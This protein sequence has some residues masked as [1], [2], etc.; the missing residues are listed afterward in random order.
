MTAI[1]QHGDTG[2]IVPRAGAP[3][4]GVPFFEKICY[5]FGDAGGTVITGLIANFLTFY[6]TDV[7]GLAPGIVGILFLS[8]R[9]F[10]AVSDPLIGIM[11]DRTRTRWG[12]FRPYLLWTAIPVGLS[13]FLTFQSPDLGYDGK[14]AYAAATYFLLALSYSL[15]NVPYCALITRMTDSAREGVSCQSVRFAMVAIA[16]FTV[17]V[18]LPIMVRHLGGADVARG[19]CDGVAILSVAAVAMFVIC[20]LFV[21][22]RVPETGAAEPPLRIAIANTLKNDQ[23]RLTFVMTLLLI[24]IFNTK[25][26]AA[27]YFITYVL[28]GDSTYQALFF[29]TAT[30][31][32]FLGSVLV[33]LFTRRFDVRTVYVWVNLLL[34]AGHFAAFFV[35]GGYPMLWLMLVALCCIALGCTLPLHFTLIQLADQYGEWKLGTRSSGMSFAFNQFFVKLAWALAG[36]L[37]S[38][39]LVIVSYKAGAGNQTPLSLTGIRLLSTVIPG[40][41]HLALALTASRLILNRATIDRMTAARAA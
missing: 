19:Y 38:G 3:A 5:G 1:A 17:S 27:L 35:P 2:G 29:G 26:G 15:N 7:F 8:L 12:K 40:V 31:G 11:A 30:A 20:F 14:V 10:D 41:M 23:L 34:V 36:A 21:R 25:G 18:G 39:V 37:I 33:Q 24:G 32:G 6:Y 9:V 13:C 16:S 4:R 22:E 28:K